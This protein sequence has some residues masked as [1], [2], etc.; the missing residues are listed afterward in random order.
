MWR[1]SVQRRLAGATIVALVV[2]ALLVV[3]F[4][5]VRAV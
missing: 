5:A 3:V 4:T 1:G 2:F